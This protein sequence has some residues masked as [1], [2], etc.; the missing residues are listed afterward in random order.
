MLR[1]AGKVLR[2]AQPSRVLALVVLPVLAGL[3]RLPP[4]A[5]LAVPGDRLRQPG[6][7]ER[8]RRRPA[9]RAQLGVVE[10]VAAVVA[11]AVL[12]VPDECRGRR[13]SARG[14]GAS[15]R[16]SRTPRRRRCRP[17]PARPRGAR[18]RL[19]RSDP[20]RGATRAPACRRRRPAA[21]RPSSAFVTKSGISFSGYWFEPYV[22]AP[23]VIE[24]VDAVRARVGEH[25]QVA[26]GLGRR[27]RARRTQRVV[28]ARATAGVEVAVHLVG[29]DLHV[30][31]VA[32]ARPLEQRLRAEH[33]G[34][35]ELARL[36][37]RPVDVRLR[38][39][40]DDR[41]ATRRRPSATAS[42]SA[43][44]PWWNSC[45]TPSRLARLPA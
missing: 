33:L 14:S 38:G 9:E 13:R 37:D 31:D 35:D 26:A 39:E 25:L 21:A 22:L 27:V 24:R 34:V 36:E 5:V 3:D 16:C 43:M 40:V 28:L 18:A 30:A 10:R 42:A 6:L 32:L 11:G 15:P 44:S 4:V 2:R 8:V 23:R 45:G 17:R 41:L 29:R 12:D 1:C 19:R 7:A 20:R